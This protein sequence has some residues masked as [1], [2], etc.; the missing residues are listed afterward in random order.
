MSASKQGQA[1]SGAQ[2]RLQTRAR[3]RNGKLVPIP[4]LVGGVGVTQVHRDRRVC[5]GCWRATWD[6]QPPIKS[7][8]SAGSQEAAGLGGGLG[9]GRASPVGGMKPEGGDKCALGGTLGQQSR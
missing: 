2:I 6:S 3:S 8:N 9:R 1:D 7:Q 5:R 4:H